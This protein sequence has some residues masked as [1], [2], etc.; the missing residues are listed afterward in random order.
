[1]ESGICDTFWRSVAL[2]FTRAAAQLGRAPA[3]PAGADLEDEIGVDLCV[4]VRER[5]PHG[6]ETF[7]DE[8][9]ELLKRA[10]D[11]WKRSAPWL[12]TIT[13]SCTGYAP[14]PTVEMLPQRSP[15]SKTVPP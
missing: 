12:A 10:D 8:V 9:R 5:D 1:M 3:E 4:V 6:E 13:A 7:L 2:N 11:R 15:V 14:S